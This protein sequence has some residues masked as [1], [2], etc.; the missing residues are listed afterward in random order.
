MAEWRCLNAEFQSI[1]VSRI[2]LGC[3]IE[4]CLVADR[5]SLTAEFNQ[6]TAAQ[7]LQGAVNMHGREAQ[8]IG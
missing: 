8:G 4:A 6:S 3:F 7:N 5:Q 2:K 1:E